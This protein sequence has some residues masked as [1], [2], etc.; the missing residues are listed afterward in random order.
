MNTKIKTLKALVKI[1]KALKKKG[2]KV[3]FTN[4][5][6]DIIHVG[7][8][9]Y[10]KAARKLGDLL[11]VAVNSDASVR[12]LKG[13][14]RPVNNKNDRMEVLSEFPFVD[15]VVLFK[16]DTPHKAIKAVLPQVLVKGGDWSVKN[17]VGGDVVRAAGGRV[18]NVPLIKNKST[19]NMIKRAG[20]IGKTGKK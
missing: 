4:G 20:K 5:C 14:G 2:K 16:E 8:T 15:Y 3:V 6:F 7:H 12:K 9:R 11:I 19:T 1:V 17:I 10:L 13:P 18:L